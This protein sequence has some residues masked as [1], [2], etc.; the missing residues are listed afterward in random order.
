VNAPNLAG[1]PELARKNA[2]KVLTVPSD[3]E[4]E[5]VQSYRDTLS[6]FRDIPGNRGTFLLADRS[7]RKA[8]GVSLWES[9]EAMAESSDRAKQLR[10][11]AT[12][13]VS[14]EIVLVDE[15]EIAAWDVDGS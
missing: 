2:S 12:S 11:Q 14:G 13:G 10:Q 6:F 8:I 1:R 4:D 3:R 5:A 9:E 7:G 15:Y